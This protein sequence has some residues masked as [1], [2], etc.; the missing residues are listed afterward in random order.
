[1]TA[2]IPRPIL[3]QVSFQAC[4]IRTSLGILGR[5][6]ALLVLRDVG[7]RRISRFNELVRANPGLTPRALSLLLLDLQREGLV[8]RSADPASPRGRVRYSLTPK[9]AD[10]L[11]VVA[12]LIEFGMRHYSDRVFEDGKPRDLTEVFPGMQRALIGPLLPYARG[13]DRGIRRRSRYVP[14]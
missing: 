2:K 12:A 9:G 5:K 8:R 3:P 10:V 1:M 11:P 4:P 14:S 13:A 6:W 7:L